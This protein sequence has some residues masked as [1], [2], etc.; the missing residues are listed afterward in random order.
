[1][2]WLR[3]PVSAHHLLAASLR[4]TPL[5]W[6][7]AHDVPQEKCDEIIRTAGASSLLDDAMFL[8]AH[9]VRRLLG[10]LCS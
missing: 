5:V 7:S 6:T 10:I 3:P 8:N 9:R 4:Q 1:M 2:G